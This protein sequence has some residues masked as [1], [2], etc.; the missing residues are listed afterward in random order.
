MT[1]IQNLKEGVIL[2]ANT[3]GTTDMGM[4]DFYCCKRA[5]D[6]EANIRT[7]R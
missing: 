5:K 4:L 3:E 1:S 2:N 6:Q 7:W